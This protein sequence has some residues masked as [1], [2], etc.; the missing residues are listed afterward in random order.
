MTGLSDKILGEIRAKNIRPAARWRFQAVNWIKIVLSASAVVAGSLAVS[1]TFFLFV[2]YEW[3]FAAYPDTGLL[4]HVIQGIPYFWLAVLGAFIVAGVVDFNRIKGG[5]RYRLSAVV[6]VYL[7]SSLILGTLLFVSGL[8]E[9][10]DDALESRVPLYQDLVWHKADFWTQP[11]LGL[12][13]GT[14]ISVISQDRFLIRDF[15]GRIWLIDSTG[16]SWQK[17]SILKDDETLK[18]NGTKRDDDAFQATEVRS[19]N[20][21]KDRQVC[22]RRSD[23][24]C[25]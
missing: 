16:A 18:L 8:G 12:L 10:L 2:D 21:L 24:G 19:W 17:G 14:V 22:I 7:A 23:P 3:E 25:Q 11:D 6:A 1:A 4:M 9:N 5:Y 15:N 20:S 13:A